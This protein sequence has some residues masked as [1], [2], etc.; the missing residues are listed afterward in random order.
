LALQRLSPS[1]PAAIAPFVIRLG[2][3]ALADVLRRSARCSACGAKSATLM[4]PSWAD[5]RRN[6]FR[7]LPPHRGRLLGENLGSRFN[8]H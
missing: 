7:I 6:S 3:D 4:H 2:P 5:K 1:A 8:V